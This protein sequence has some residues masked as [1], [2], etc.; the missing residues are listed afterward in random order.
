MPF[1]CTD[2]FATDTLDVS[3]NTAIPVI[4]SYNSQGECKPLCFRYT[5]ENGDT[6]KVSIDRI[7]YSKHNSVFGTIYR[8]L[9]TVAGSQRYVSL[10]YHD[11]TRTWSLRNS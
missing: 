4:C 6:E 1:I 9:V 8:C 3:Q 10:Y 2:P 7:E 5:Y 11:K